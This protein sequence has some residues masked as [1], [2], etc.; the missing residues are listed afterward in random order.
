MSMIMLTAVAGTIIR[1]QKFMNT[2]MST[3]M[4]TIII[5][6]KVNIA[7]VGTTMNT[8]RLLMFQR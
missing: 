4:A 8:P 1:I 7:A 6:K 2:L 5:M 3:K